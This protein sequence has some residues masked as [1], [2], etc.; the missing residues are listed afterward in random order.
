MIFLSARYCERVLDLCPSIAQAWW[1]VGDE[2]FSK[3]NQRLTSSNA[4]NQCS[5]AGTT[6]PK[7]NRDVSREIFIWGIAYEPAGVIPF[8][9]PGPSR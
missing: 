3:V 4:Q 8:K 9:R 6:K 1:E 2:K 7:A 5:R